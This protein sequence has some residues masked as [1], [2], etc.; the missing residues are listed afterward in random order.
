MFLNVPSDIVP[1]NN[2]PH[3]NCSSWQLFNSLIIPR[4]NYSSVPLQMVICKE[5][6]RP[7]DQNQGDGGARIVANDHLDDPASSVHLQMVIC[8]EDHPSYY[9]NQRDGGARIVA[10]AHLD[11]PASPV[12][13]HT[14][15]NGH[16]QRGRNSGWPAFCWSDG[17]EIRTRSAPSIEDPQYKISAQTDQQFRS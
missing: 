13:L 9:Q 15:V 6:G 10:N 16:L 14:F 4:D 17:A 5:D 2:V 1:R 3:D 12:L 11:D 7:D 8:K